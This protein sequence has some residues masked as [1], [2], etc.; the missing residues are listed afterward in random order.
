MWRKII[1]LKYQNNDVISNCH[2][3]LP[4]VKIKKRFM[5]KAKTEHISQND[6]ET[7]KRHS[8]SIKGEI[9]WNQNSMIKFVKMNFCC[10]L[11][12]GS[13]CINW[14]GRSWGD[15]SLFQHSLEFSFSQKL[16]RSKNE[17]QEEFW[18]WCTASSLLP[19]QIFWS[20]WEWFWGIPAKWTFDQ[21]SLSSFHQ[22]NADQNVVKPLNPEKTYEDEFLIPV[23]TESPS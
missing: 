17:A 21:P 3:F 23:K 6:A 20:S 2:H 18:G 7:F 22:E 10:F 19:T 8:W 11:V 4:W 12:H 15:T 5:S 13:H 9:V 1:W 14:V 16:P